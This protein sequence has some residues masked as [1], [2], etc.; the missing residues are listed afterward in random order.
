MKILIFVHNLTD[1]GAERVAVEWAKG[2]LQKGYTVGVVI[3]CP[4]LTPISYTLPETISL[5]NIYPNRVIP[6]LNQITICVK[7]R[8]ILKKFRPDK[9]ISVHGMFIQLLA[10]LGLGIECIN[11]EHNAYERPESAPMNKMINFRK[12]F[13]NKFYKKVT[14]LTTKDTLIARDYGINGFY[15]PNP[16]A[17]EPLVDLPI[18]KKIILAAG[19]LDAGYCKG[20]DILIKAFAIASKN[21]DWLLQIAGSGSLQA[22]NK[23]R[24][25]AKDCGVEDRVVFVGFTN[26]LLE[27]Y[28]NAEIFVLSSRYE[29]FG[30]VLIEAMSQGCACV[31]CDYGGRQR[32]IVGSDENALCCTPDDIDGLAS[33]MYLVMN[34]K[35][36]RL[37]LQ[38]NAIERSKMFLTGKITDRWEEIFIS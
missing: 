5:F 19:R 30:L 3:C 28:R 36:L 31:A 1:G 7:L 22:L 9:F 10:P 11:T 25:L 8:R 16:L 23:Y 24:N 34:S 18:K 15:L 12:F 21:T 37:K 33:A 32:E 20:F 6:Y 2:F 35:E 4:L 29:G 14:T 17:F 26:N 27:Y 38:K 13:L